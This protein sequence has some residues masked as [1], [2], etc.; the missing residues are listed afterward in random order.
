MW[1]INNKVITLIIGSPGSG[2]S[3]Y[4]AKI[5][6]ECNKKGISVFANYPT[7]G[8]YPVDLKSMSDY[9]LSRVGV[10]GKAVLI[11]DE[12]GLVYNSRSSTQ[13]GNKS[14][15]ADV[16]HWYATTRHRNT[17]VFVIVQ[18]W[19]RVDTVL[20]ELATEVIMCRKGVLGFTTCRAYQSETTLIEDGN[21]NALEFN[22]L[23][24]RI[25]WS[26]F[27]RPN[28]Y[29]MFDSF[30][31]DKEYLAPNWDEYDRDHFPRKQPLWKRVLGVLVPLSLRPRMGGVS[32]PSRQQGA[33]VATSSDIDVS[34]PAKL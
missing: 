12:A 32:A 6:K 17:Q 24:S 3:T 13:K 19:K 27:W 23:F 34:V 16:Y 30:H 33:A 9:D 8:S 28:Y 5:V 29:H 1:V 10:S 18:S 20:R 2:K 25:G 11:V 22:E 21:G 31:L 15:G 14:F 26:C 4:S 7:L